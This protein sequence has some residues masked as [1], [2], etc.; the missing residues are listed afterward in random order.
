EKATGLNA[1]VFLSQWRRDVSHYSNY[2]LL[3]RLIAKELKIQDHIAS[4]DEVV[5]TDVM[6]FEEV[7]KKVIRCIRDRIIGTDS[8]NGVRATIQRRRDGHWANPILGAEAGGPNVYVAVYDAI[9]A[10]AGLLELRRQFGRGLSYQNANAMYAAY[11][12]ELYR[13]DQLYRLFHEAAEEV[14]LK[15][16]DI[17][18]PMR[19]V[20]ESCYSGWFL[21]QIAVTWGS[22]ID[23]GNGRGLLDAWMLPEVTNQQDFYSR[24][25]KPILD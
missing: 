13:F 4:F 7:E 25:V 16:W 1:S 23:A 11:V 21:D 17:L 9:E 19:E 22:F 20:V 12:N 8:W 10:A 24:H 6:T 15:G 2:N 14:D 3:S 5:L 18:K